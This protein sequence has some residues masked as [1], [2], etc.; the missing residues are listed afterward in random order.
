MIQMP[1]AYQQSPANHRAKLHVVSIKQYAVSK[2]F[3]SYLLLYWI[4]QGSLKRILKLH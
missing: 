2:Q 4:W 3:S 1:K